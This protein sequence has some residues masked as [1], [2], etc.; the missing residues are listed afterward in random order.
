MMAVITPER[1]AED[2]ATAST[3]VATRPTTSVK[4]A[5]IMIVR[6]A[7]IEDGAAIADRRQREHAARGKADQRRS[8]AAD[9]AARLGRH[10]HHA[11]GGHED[12]GHHRQGH[13][14][15]EEDQAEDRDLD[16]LG[17]QIS[18]GDDERALAH[19]DEHQRGRGDLRRGR[20]RSPRARMPSRDAAAARRSTASGRRGKPARTESR[21]E[22]AHA[23]RRRAEAAGQ[24]ALHRVAH[25]LA[26]RG[27][28]GEDDPEPR[29]RRHAQLTPPSSQRRPC[30]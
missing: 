9:H 17:L 30:N 20:R 18:D 22:T 24:L 10:D 29:I 1:A 21:T 13:R 12:R 11:R 2:R 5:A 7:E 4:V 25:R 19:G 15:A 16:R 28:D 14:I 26:A 6:Q 3:V 27:D 8:D 23:S